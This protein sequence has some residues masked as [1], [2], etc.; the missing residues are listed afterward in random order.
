MPK[1]VTAIWVLPLLGDMGF[2]VADKRIRKACE[3]IISYK[4]LNLGM[5][6]PELK[7]EKI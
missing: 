5:V 7:C 6:S 1:Y 2:T 3:Y 4:E